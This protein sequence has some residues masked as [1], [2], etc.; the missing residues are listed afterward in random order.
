MTDIGPGLDGPQYLKPVKRCHLAWRILFAL[1]VI[2]ISPLIACALI[3][4]GI[5]MAGMVI[6]IFGR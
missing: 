1:A 5:V 3:L 4:M 6:F 2:A